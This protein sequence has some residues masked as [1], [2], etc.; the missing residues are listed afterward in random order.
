MDIKEERQIE[1]KIEIDKTTKDAK[2]FCLIKSELQ[3]KE[4]EKVKIIS[5][6]VESLNLLFEISDGI[7]EQILDME[8]KTI[9]D[10]EKKVEAF[11]KN[12]QKLK[13]LGYNKIELT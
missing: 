2:L 12:L 1:K 4:E 3:I 13:G 9:E 7:E 10:H 11:K 6:N 8:K 5:F